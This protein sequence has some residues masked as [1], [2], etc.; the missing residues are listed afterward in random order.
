MCDF[1]LILPLKRIHMKQNILLG[2]LVLALGY[3][4]YRNFSSSAT[5]V[6]VEDRVDR[7]AAEIASKAAQNLPDS[8]G[9][10]PRFVPRRVEVPV[11]KLPNMPEAN[12]QQFTDG[13]W[14]LR[15]A[16]SAEDAYIS[17]FYSK[18]WLKFYENRNFDILINGKTVEQGR[19]NYDAKN[20]EILLSC[21]NVY[22]NNSWKVIARKE[23]I[24]L[25]GNTALNNTGIQ[26]QMIH[27]GALPVDL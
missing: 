8:V 5:P 15:G 24:V 6:S 7:E 27:S 25:I 23:M 10:K 18:R 22:F 3:L 21:Q 20:E 4:T 16:S 19:W 14:R 26:I 9:G 2:A 17:D 1:D 12:K 13:W 11:D